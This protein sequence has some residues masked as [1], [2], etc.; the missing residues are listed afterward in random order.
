MLP[1]LYTLNTVQVVGYLRQTVPSSV[2]CPECGSEMGYYQELEL[3]LDSWPECDFIAASGGAYFIS[4]KLLMELKKIDGSGYTHRPVNISIS[5]DFRRSY[6]EALGMLGGIGRFHYL[7]ITGQCDGPWL[8]HIKGEVCSICGRPKPKLMDFGTWLAEIDGDTPP[9]PRQVFSET[10]H[11]EDFF[12]LSEPGPPLI[13]ERVVAILA[14]TGNLRREKI[15]DKDTI[16]QLMP[17]Y[18][19]SLEKI[20]WQI[21][22]CVGLGPAKWVT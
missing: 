5:D 11:G 20:G 1:K 3:V 16:R 7:M 13:T 15:A 14:E 2:N 9:Q 19:E 21:E 17:K 18:A 12:Y 10:W 22:R 8:R 4:E 6:P